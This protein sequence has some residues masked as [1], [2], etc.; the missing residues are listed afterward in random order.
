MMAAEEDRDKFD[1][2]IGPNLNCGIAE[3]ITCVTKF[4]AIKLYI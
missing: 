1:K 4:H 2:G 3:K